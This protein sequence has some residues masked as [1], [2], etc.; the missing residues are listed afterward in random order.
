MGSGPR[1]CVQPCTVRGPRSPAQS[2]EI[3]GEG[4]PCG[5]HGRASSRSP[6][7]GPRATGE[8]RCRAVCS[9]GTL[10]PP[11]RH[12]LKRSR[13]LRTVRAPPSGGPQAQRTEQRVLSLSCPQGPARGP[14]HRKHEGRSPCT[15][16]HTPQGRSAARLSKSRTDGAATSWRRAGARPSRGTAA[17]G[18]QRQAG[19]RGPV[20]HGEA[21][22]PATQGRPRRGQA[23]LL[24]RAGARVPQTPQETPRVTRLASRGDTWPRSRLRSPGRRGKSLPGTEPRPP[25][26][27]PRG[28]RRP[29]GA[30]L[31]DGPSAAGRG[32]S[33]SAHRQEA[34]GRRGRQDEDGPRG[35]LAGAEPATPG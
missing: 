13:S 20:S 10:W 32:R 31:S 23:R 5:R 29:D 14:Q 25:P 24:H 7:H 19:D 26:G 22:P 2:P 12:L 15:P 33:P 16:N 9:Q 1:P 3:R 6:R 30:P 35:K 11:P 4:A 18:P 34:S 27:T 17:E 8:T 28:G 21:H